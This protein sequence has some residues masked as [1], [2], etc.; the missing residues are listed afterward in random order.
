MKPIWLQGGNETNLFRYVDN[1]DEN[2]G[3]ANLLLQEPELFA[4]ESFD[5]RGRIYP[6]TTM[7]HHNADYLRAM[8]LFGKSWEVTED[9]LSWLIIQLANTYGNKVD[10]MPHDQLGVWIGEFEEEIRLC[11]RDIEA[12]FNIWK[13][14]D[15]PFQ[16][17]AACHEYENYMAATERGETYRSSLPIAVDASQSGVQHFSLSLRDP[18][19]AKR[20][21]LGRGDTRHD[22]YEDC[23][24]VAKRLMEEDKAH[25][26]L[27]AANDPVTEEDRA[28]KT[29]RCV[30]QISHAR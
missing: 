4:P 23:L 13:T 30:H 12:S 27:L 29:V 8:F 19:D 2:L 21:N 3:E 20:V 17:L 15:E 28:A 14:A 6:V 24:V 5:T 1:D 25:M 22:I 26:T 10:K 11:G 9:N 18:R 16:F 7:N